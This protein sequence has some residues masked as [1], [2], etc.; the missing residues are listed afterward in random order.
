MGFSQAVV[1]KQPGGAVVH[2]PNANKLAS[3]G[4]LFTKYY[5][6]GHIYICP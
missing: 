2:T 6:S 1:N 3:E 4:L 5:V